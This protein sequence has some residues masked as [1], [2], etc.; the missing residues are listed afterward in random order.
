[1][2][3]A[4]KPQPSISAGSKR[5][6]LDAPTSTSAAKR[7]KTSVAPKENAEEKKDPA[8]RW[9]WIDLVRPEMCA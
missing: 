4:E 1:M 6:S 3:S 7:A 8:E 2:T 9:K 5:K